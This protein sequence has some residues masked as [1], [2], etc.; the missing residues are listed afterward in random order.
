[1]VANILPVGIKGIVL[2]GLIAAIMSS[3]DSTLNSASTLITLNL[4]KPKNPNLTA[5]QTA[6]IGR[7]RGCPKSENR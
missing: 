4:V 3:I 1:M 6:K 7:W 2:A 5:K